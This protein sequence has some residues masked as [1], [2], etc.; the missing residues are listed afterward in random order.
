MFAGDLQEHIRSE[1]IGV[2]NGGDDVSVCVFTYL[3]SHLVMFPGCTRESN[4]EQ[5]D[6][7]GDII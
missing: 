6:E 3:M 2:E 1:N 7:G 4:G 5:R